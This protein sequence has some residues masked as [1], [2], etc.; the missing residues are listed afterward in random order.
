[1]VNFESAFF[2]ERAAHAHRCAVERAERGE[3]DGRSLFHAERASSVCA[4]SL[5][6]TRGV[7]LE[8]AARIGERSLM[9]RA[10]APR[11]FSKAARAFPAIVRL[12]LSSAKSSP[13]TFDSSD[14]AS[15]SESSGSWTSASAARKSSTTALKLK[16]CA[17]V[18]AQ[19]PAPAG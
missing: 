5:F 16:V 13:K 3:D 6:P 18:T 14:G 10:V 4:P 15:V 9:V 7:G 2:I 11:F 1:M 8:V 17:P 19:A 12:R